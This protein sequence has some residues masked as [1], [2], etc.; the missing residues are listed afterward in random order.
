LQIIAVLV[1]GHPTTFGYLNQAL[2]GVNAL[3]VAGRPGE[4]AGNAMADL[5]FG[6]VRLATP[7]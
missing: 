4:E 6:K 3:L 1:N 5:I 7:E 2:D